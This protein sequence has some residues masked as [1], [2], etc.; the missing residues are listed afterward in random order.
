MAETTE[1]A[2]KCASDDDKDSHYPLLIGG[3]Y[4][5]NKGLQLYNSIVIRSD[6]TYQYDAYVVVLS[7]FLSLMMD[8]CHVSN[9]SQSDVEC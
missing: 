5:P 7:L 3:L 2:S 8:A 4:G 6:R 1:Q 9:P